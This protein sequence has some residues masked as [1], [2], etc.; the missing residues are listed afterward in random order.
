LLLHL[1]S[2]CRWT[3][4]TQARFILNG[5]RHANEILG[6]TAFVEEEWRV[7]GEYVFD[8]EGGRHQ[9]F[10]APLRDTT[11]L[12]E[13]IRPYDRIRVEQS[14]KFSAV[15]AQKLWS[16]AGMTETEQWRHD[17]EYGKHTPALPQGCRT[18]AVVSPFSSPTSPSSPPPHVC[19]T[20]GASRTGNRPCETHIGMLCS[21][22]DI[23]P[24]SI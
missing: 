5:L 20:R 9:A 1:A 18:G 19:V 21:M 14:H 12:G 24:M 2:L 7:I 22:G 3:T 6:E 17:D 16:L 11:V 23:P 8:G 13:V 4:L 10:Y 15:E